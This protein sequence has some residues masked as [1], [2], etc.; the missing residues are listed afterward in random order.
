M[1]R[2]GQQQIGLVEAL[3]TALDRLLRGADIDECLSLYPHLAVELEPLLRVAGIVRAEVTQPLPPEMERWLATGAQEFAALA[4]QMLARRHARRN[5][6]K[7]LRKAAVQRVLVGALAVAVLLASVDTASAQSL[8]GDPLYV[9]KVA[10]EDLTLSM[11]SDPVQ[12][13]KLHVAY[14]RRRLSEIEVITG[15]TA[16]DPQVLRESLALLSNHIRGAVIESHDMDVADVSVDVTVL[17]DEVQTALPQLASKV[18]DASPLLENVQEQIESVIKPTASPVPRATVSPVPSLL[19]TTLVESPTTVE[20]TASETVPQTEREPEQV[21]A[22]PPIATPLPTVRQPLPSPT[23][24][25]IEPTV[26]SAPA[27][28]VLPIPFSPTVLLPSSPTMMPTAPSTETPPTDVPLPTNTP[29]LTAT[30]PPTAI[31]V[32]P[33]EPTSVG[34]TPQPPPTARPPHPTITPTLAP[35]DTPPAT[36]APPVTP[37]DPPPATPPATPSPPVTPTDTPPATPPATPAPPVTPTDTLPAT[38]APPVTP[39]LV[40]TATPTEALSLTPS[41]TPT[42]EAGRPA[43]TPS[44]SDPSG[45]PTPTPNVSGAHGANV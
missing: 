24:H 33:T 22:A 3:D 25:Q 40:P 30:V 28:T 10:R 9:W 37:T 11:T 45:V 8:P 5:L 13:S 6:L 44:R 21:D 1:I 32:P 29:S 34:S 41:V 18:P 39:T 7:P 14:A 38:P 19:P 42:E 15:K 20:V 4:D 35:T 17:L 36:P 27:P 2:L 43:I 16:I 12:R 26:I 23:S 31:R